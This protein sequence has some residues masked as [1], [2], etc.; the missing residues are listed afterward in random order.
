MLEINRPQTVTVDL[1]GVV[2]LAVYSDI[3]E[4]SFCN[5][6]GVVIA[7]AGAVLRS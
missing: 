1:T 5:D 3:S 4:G 7:L 2:T 6:D